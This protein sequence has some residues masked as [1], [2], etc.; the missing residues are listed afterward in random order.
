MT[1]QIQ[2][3][4]MMMR[5]GLLL[6]D[7][8]HIESASYSPTWRT[9]T[10]L[11]SF[12]VE[13]KLRDAGL[14][15]FFMAGELK[16]TA[17]GRGANTIRRGI[18]RVLARGRKQALNCMQIAQIKPASLLGIPYVVVRAYSFHIQKDAM[19]QGHAERKL[20]QH[21]QGRACA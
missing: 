2:S 13:R 11:D 6:P 5:E 14:H 3:G 19:L 18:T 8:A 12:G 7:A 16:V 1:T 15:L 9:M 20:D 10:A 17:L 4:A 21:N